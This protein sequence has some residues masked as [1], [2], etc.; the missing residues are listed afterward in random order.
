MEKV[1]SVIVPVYNGEKYLRETI[2]SILVQTFSDFELII[3]DDGSIDS[4]SE[5][6]EELAKC[7]DRIVVYYQQNKGVSAARN[8]GIRK[9][10]GKYVCFIDSDD[11]VEPDMFETLYKNMVEYNVDISCCGIMQETLDGQ[12]NTQ[13]CTGEQVH[14]EDNKI[15]LEKFFSNP[16]YREVLYG[17]VNKLFKTELVTSVCFNEKYKI[18]EDL[19]FS[20]ECLEKT[21][22]FYFENRGLYHY[23]KREGS[24]TTSKFSVKRFD[25]IYV[26]DILLN[27]CKE[28]HPEAYNSAL[29]WAFIHKLNMC[30]SLSKFSNIKKENLDFYKECYSFCK[31]NRKNVWGKLTLK[32][33]LNYFVIKFFPFIY[34]LVHR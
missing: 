12:K 23:I 21:K 8:E 13:F 3:I 6:C 31:K 2:K 17:P 9:A 10:N 32:K 4:T 22:S 29:Y 18:G 25:Y 5:I 15:L 24:A 11:Y 28:K 33:K 14:I 19:L 7:D 26:A 16:M 27:K 34:K 1:I 30:C 20:F